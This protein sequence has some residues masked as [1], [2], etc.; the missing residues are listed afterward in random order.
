M[1]CKS[2][3]FLSGNKEKVRKIN[4]ICTCVFYLCTKTLICATFH[5]Q[6]ASFDDSIGNVCCFM[7]YID[8][9]IFH[10]YLPIQLEMCKFAVD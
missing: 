8:F 2:S 3:H 6:F 7:N 10:F 1:R 5:R 9:F 4:K